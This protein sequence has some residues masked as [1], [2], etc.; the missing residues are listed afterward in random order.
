[1]KT[2]NTAENGRSFGTFVGVFVPT[3]LLLCHSATFYYNKTAVF[4]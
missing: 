1:M 2:V 4:P 3:T